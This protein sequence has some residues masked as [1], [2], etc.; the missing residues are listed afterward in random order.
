MMYLGAESVAVGQMIPKPHEVLG[1]IHST[2]YTRYEHTQMKRT[3]PK[4]RRKWKVM[5][6]KYQAHR[7]A[8]PANTANA[9]CLNSTWLVASLARFF[10]VEKTWA[11]LTA[12][13]PD[14]L[15]HSYHFP[16]SIG[17]LFLGPLYPSRSSP[18]WLCWFFEQ[19]LCH[20]LTSVGG[21]AKR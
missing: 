19:Q 7:L 12:G 6:L 18:M 1:S 15:I 3:N 2:T 10:H 14:S 16:K 9:T 4:G 11:L 5:C 8:R 17:H 21:R 20:L 13:C